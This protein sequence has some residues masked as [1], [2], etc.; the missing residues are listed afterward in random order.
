MA[1]TRIA[2]ATI[3]NTGSYVTVLNIISAGSLRMIGW[4][5][6]GGGEEST[7][8]RLTIDSDIVFTITGYSL[9]T[10]LT[11]IELLKTIIANSMAVTTDDAVRN[12][13]RFPFRRELK[14]EVQTGASGLTINTLYELK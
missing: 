12:L 9:P 1:S 6:N 8:I 11:Y 14:I 4:K 3:T 13:S 2:R 10:T 7:N 5:G